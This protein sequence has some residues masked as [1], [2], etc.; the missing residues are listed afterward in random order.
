VH[1]PALTN[2]FIS[3]L[4]LTRRMNH[5]LF[6]ESRWFHTLPSTRYMYAHSSTRANSCDSVSKRAPWLHYNRISGG[7]I[8]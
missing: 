4:P 6:N 7:W 5:E 2:V 1:I 8:L 3:Q